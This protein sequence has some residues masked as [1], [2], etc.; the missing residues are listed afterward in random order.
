MKKKLDSKLK[1]LGATPTS[2]GDSKRQSSDQ[3]ASN[4]GSTDE[5]KKLERISSVTNIEDMDLG[6]L[7]GIQIFVVVLSKTVCLVRMELAWIL[8]SIPNL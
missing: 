3:L 6:K 1:K 7:T 8:L 2:T 4:V 5:K